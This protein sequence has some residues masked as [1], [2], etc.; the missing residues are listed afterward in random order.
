MGSSRRLYVNMLQVGTYLIEVKVTRQM[1]R[2]NIAACGRNRIP[3]TETPGTV[4]FHEFGGEAIQVRVFL[5]MQTIFPLKRRT[6]R[7]D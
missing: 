1:F 4:G 2:L 5:M 6:H 7:F 3:S